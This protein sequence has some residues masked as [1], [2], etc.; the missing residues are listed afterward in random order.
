MRL[1]SYPHQ[2]LFSTAELRHGA[3]SDRT[4]GNSNYSSTSAATCTSVTDP[5]HIS[6]LGNRPP[7]ANTYSAVASESCSTMDYCGMAASSGQPSGTARSTSP[8]DGWTGSDSD[9][10]GASVTDSGIASNTSLSVGSDHS[11][12][13]RGSVEIDATV[14]SKLSPPA[15]TASDR[16][17]APSSPL[18]A[19]S[20]DCLL[21]PPPCDS[22]ATTNS[23]GVMR[24]NA[25]S[26][27]QNGD[28]CIT[29]SN[30]SGILPFNQRRCILHSFFIIY[31]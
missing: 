19:A 15:S 25:V 12:N 4:L 8:R 30:H 14:G 26:A 27:G 28:S 1:P 17:G 11:E 5:P 20:A 6:G 2:P 7:P 24:V 10:G 18:V 3:V 21:E 23:C 31:L 16:I 29:A 13:D 9:Y 22:G